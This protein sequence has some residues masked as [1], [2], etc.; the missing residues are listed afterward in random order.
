LRAVRNDLSIDAQALPAIAV[1]AFARPED[2]R[3]LLAAGFQAH[4]TKPYQIV[5]LVSAIRRLAASHAAAAAAKPA[6]HGD[7]GTPSR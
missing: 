5:Q 1:T 2:H 7:P 3:R 4:L 6:A